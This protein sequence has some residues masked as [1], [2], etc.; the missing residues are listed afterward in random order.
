MPVPVRR[1][2]LRRSIRLCSR[3]VTPHYPHNAAAGPRPPGRPPPRSNGRLPWQG[4]APSPGAGQR[5]PREAAARGRVNGA[6]TAAG[7][8]RGAALAP[9]GS[10]GGPRPRAFRKPTPHLLGREQKWTGPTGPWGH[11]YTFLEPHPTVFIKSQCF[12]TIFLAH[13]DTNCPLAVGPRLV[14]QPPEAN[15]NTQQTHSEPV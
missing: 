8:R 13:R 11:G 14:S 4:R 12:S 7:A 9:S 3:G 5:D 10:R 15:L 2:P 6:A 1:G